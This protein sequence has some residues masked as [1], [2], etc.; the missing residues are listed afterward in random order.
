MREA[1]ARP[2]D[3]HRHGIRAVDSDGGRHAADAARPGDRVE[4]PAAAGRYVSVIGS[5][6]RDIDPGCRRKGAG[7]RA[8]CAMGD[9]DGLRVDGFRLVAG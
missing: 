7:L 5:A 3:V 1:A 8:V 2:A 4:G 9:G 6:Q